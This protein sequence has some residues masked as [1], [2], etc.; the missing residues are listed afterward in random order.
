MSQDIWTQCGGKS[1][2]RQLSAQAWRI[3]ENQYQTS[4][5][6]L[7]DSSQEQ[8]ILEEAIEEVKPRRPSGP[9]WANLHFL[10]WTP[11]RYP[12]LK[13][14]SRF[15]GRTARSLWYGSTKLRTALAETAYYRFRLLN[16]TDAD[17]H[18]KADLTA[19]S[20][21]L[22]STQ[23]VDLCLPPFLEH[24]KDISDP[25]SYASSQP[26]GLAMRSDGVEFFQYFS[27]RDKDS[28][29]NVGVFSPQAFKQRDVPDTECS[30]WHVYATKLHAEF[31]LASFSVSERYAFNRSDFE[32][33]G[34][35]PVLGS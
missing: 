29:I 31:S 4:T 32:V 7:V 14:G 27:A 26:L 18:I 3:V 16:D 11:F 1:N 20:I 15:G 6:K 22:E 13:Y 10:L 2:L 35:L 12:P 8:R 21:P 34:G 5:L 9:E 17:V 30:T 33:N 19:F 28:G 25:K 24:K 23:G